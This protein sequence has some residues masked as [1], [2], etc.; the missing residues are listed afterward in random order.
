MDRVCIVKAV[1]YWGSFFTELRPD[2]VDDF[3]KDIIDLLEEELSVGNTV[4]LST[5][6]GPKGPLIKFLND[7]GLPTNYF[8]NQTVMNVKTDQITVRESG[9][10]VLRYP[11]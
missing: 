10:E 1:N 2:K 6:S 8:P 9:K 5:D 11:N 3:K 4:I 7:N